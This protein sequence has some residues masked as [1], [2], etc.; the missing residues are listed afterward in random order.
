LRRRHDPELL[1][2]VVD[3][4]DFANADAFVDAHAIVSAG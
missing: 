3:D 1:P 2:R 4:P